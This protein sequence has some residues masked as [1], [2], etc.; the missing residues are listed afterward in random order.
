MPLHVL[1]IGQSPYV[2]F[3]V[4]QF[5]ICIVCILSHSAISNPLP[6][7]L[8]P[9]PPP[10]PPPPLVASVDLLTASTILQ[11]GNIGE[12][13]MVN[14]CVQLVIDLATP[15][16]RNVVVILNAVNDTANDTED[17][18]ATSQHTIIL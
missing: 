9:L 4:L 7:T 6:S 11:E 1:H 17:V 2:L 3:C 15:L 5:N 18:T 14:V 8:I 16:D 12:R 10:P 13:N